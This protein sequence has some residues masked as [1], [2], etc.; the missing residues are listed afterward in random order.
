MRRPVVVFTAAMEAPASPATRI[1]SVCA[2]HH[3]LGL[4]A[5]IPQTAPVIPTPATTAA[6]VSTHLRRLSTTASAPRSSTVSDATSW[7]PASREVLATTSHLRPRWMSPATSHNVRKPSTTRSAMCSVTTM[8]AAG[9]TATAR[10]TSTTRG[11]TAPPHCSAGDIST[12][13]SATLSVTT[14]D[15]STMASTARIWKDSASESCLCL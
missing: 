14:L 5:S 7:I 15:V 2:P 10:S 12:M 3:S 11:R 9:T 6:H 4:S 1:P 13:E 8:P